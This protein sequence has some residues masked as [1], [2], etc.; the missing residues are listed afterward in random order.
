[1]RTWLSCEP[2][3]PILFFTHSSRI[4]SP[5]NLTYPRHHSK[6]AL[7]KFA[8]GVKTAAKRAIAN[9]AKKVSFIS[10][11]KNKKAALPAK[12]FSFGKKAV[13]TKPQQKAAIKNAFGKKAV[14]TKPQQKAAI[15]NAFGKKA[16][17]TKPQQMAAVKNAFG[18]RN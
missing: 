17:A 8:L 10:A 2:I 13:A 18:K 1:M 15:K 3:E 5:V 14:A 4:P 9:P 16:V 12:K 7:K 11:L 6:Y